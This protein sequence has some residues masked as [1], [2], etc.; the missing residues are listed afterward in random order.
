[1][2]ASESFRFG[3]MLVAIVV[4]AIKIA[5][6]ESWPELWMK[7]ERINQI[8]ANDFRSYTDEGGKGGWKGG[9]VGSF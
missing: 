4:A 5:D 6:A 7:T 2:D 8:G 3:R 1:M 9:R